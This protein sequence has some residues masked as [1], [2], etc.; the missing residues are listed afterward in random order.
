MKFVDDA[1]RLTKD[2]ISKGGPLY[3]VSHLLNVWGVFVPSK[4]VC[5]HFF[6]Y[7]QTRSDLRGVLSVVWYRNARQTPPWSCVWAISL[8]SGI[9]GCLCA[10]SST[11]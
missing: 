5:L 1:T 8:R 7:Q 2:I 6:T 3:D 10:T 9:E 4:T 11:S